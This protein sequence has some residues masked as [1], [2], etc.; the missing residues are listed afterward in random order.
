MKYF[1]RIAE[2]TFEIELPEND[3]STIK[4]NGKPIK[5]ADLQKLA[6]PNLYSLII[7]NHSYQIF[8]DQNDDGY[9]IILNGV[10]YPVELEDETTRQLRNLIKTDEKPHGAVEIKA[11]MPGLIVKYLVKEGQ[12]VKKG[13]GLVIIEA[14]KM[15]NEIRAHTN[16][17]V[18][19]I[20]RKDQESVEKDTPLLILE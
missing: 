19:K 14:M 18:K 9:Q 10:T 17:V 15:E 5:S 12:S 8:I 6:E 13:E 4:V 1:A 20:F 16:G 3:S 2:K 11:P 7:N